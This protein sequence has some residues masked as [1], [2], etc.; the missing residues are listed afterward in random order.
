MADKP[1]TKRAP[2]DEKKVVGTP[3]SNPVHRIKSC[4][5]CSKREGIFRKTDDLKHGAEYDRVQGF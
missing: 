3:S 5:S 1:L 2:H 4:E